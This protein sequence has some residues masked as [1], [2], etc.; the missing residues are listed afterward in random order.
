MNTVEETLRVIDAQ[1]GYHKRK[2]NELHEAKMEVLDKY[3]IPYSKNDADGDVM[4]HNGIQF[5]VNKQ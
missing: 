4:V 5:E 3:D 2:I 1:I